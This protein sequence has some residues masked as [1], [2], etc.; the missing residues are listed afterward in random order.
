M[1]SE[2][3]TFLKI[4]GNPKP[5]S[6]KTANFALPVI[7][8]GFPHSE[9]PGSKLIRSSPRL[10][11]AYHVL[12]R[13]CMPRHPPNALKTLDHSHCPWPSH[14]GHD[15]Y[16]QLERTRRAFKPVKTSFTRIVRLCAV[17]Q[18]KQM[19]DGG[20]GQPSHTETIGIQ[21]TLLFT[22]YQEHARA[23]ARE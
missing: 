15:Q 4:T 17:R 7:K 2:Q 19:T 16:F 14:D 8:G 11:A 3:D 1:Y 18:H 9:I 12:H 21:T 23:P 5:D 22:M 6:Q 20:L 10:I 13:L